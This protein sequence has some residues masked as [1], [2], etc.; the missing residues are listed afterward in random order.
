MSITSVYFNFH[1]FHLLYCTLTVFSSNQHSQ[2]QAKL[3]NSPPMVIQI[4]QNNIFKDALKETKKDTF[5][6]EK[7]IKVCELH[8]I[9]W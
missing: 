5:N 6:P 2:L 7:R 4:R 9:A 1:I 8:N 3:S